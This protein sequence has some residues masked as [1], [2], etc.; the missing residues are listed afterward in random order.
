MNWMLKPSRLYANEVMLVGHDEKWLASIRHNTDLD[1]DLRQ[2][3]D[4]L[5]GAAP[6]LLEAMEELSDH[7]EVTQ[8]IGE[9]ATRRLRSIINKARRRP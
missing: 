7:T 9:G 5:V 3:I 2:R 4:T 1:P 6:A 8:V